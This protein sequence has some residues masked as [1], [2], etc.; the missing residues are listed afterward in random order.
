MTI[1]EDIPYL[2]TLWIR[3]RVFGLLF[4]MCFTFTLCFGSHVEGV[5]FVRCILKKALLPSTLENV[6]APVRKSVISLRV[7]AL[8]FSQ[9]MALFRSFGSRQSL[10]L[11]FAFLGYVSEL[12]HG[13]GSVC[14][15]MIPCQTISP[16]SFSISSLYL[17]GTFHLLC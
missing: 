14:F 15:M 8:G 13:V 1:I 5:E 12:T 10:N 3:M 16:N 17:M 7:G 6:V 2:H 4:H 9:M 11:L